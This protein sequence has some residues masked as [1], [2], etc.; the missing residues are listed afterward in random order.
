MSGILKIISGRLLAL[1][2]QIFG[3]ILKREEIG[4]RRTRILSRL[5]RLIPCKSGICREF[6]HLPL[7]NEVIQPLLDK[8]EQFIPWIVLKGISPLPVL[9][10]EKDD[11]ASQV[12][13]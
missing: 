13:C 7:N 12:F 10:V 4:A 1:S 11:S 2:D 9:S 5:A 3:F 6:S 8:V